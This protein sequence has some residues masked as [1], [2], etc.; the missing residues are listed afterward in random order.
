MSRT[1]TLFHCRL[2]PFVGLPLDRRRVPA[3]DKNKS[4]VDADSCKFF[5]LIPI[6]VAF[7]YRA[8]E[9]AQAQ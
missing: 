1:S 6:F 3:A 4:V 7:F 5:A 2:N 8:Q 9:M